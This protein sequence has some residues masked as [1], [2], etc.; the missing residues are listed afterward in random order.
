MI[1][2][3]LWYVVYYGW[4]LF[5]VFIAI[6]MRTGKDAGSVQDRGTQALLWIVIFASMTACEFIRRLLAPNMPAAASIAGIIVLIAGLAVRCIAIITL[7]KAFSANVAIKS[8]QSIQRTGIYSVL[9]H[10][11]YSG[12]LLIFLG[13]GLH[14]R[15]WQ[16]L[17][18]A[19]LPSTVALLYRI[20]IEEAVLNTT[21]GPDYAAYSRAT[22]RLIPGLY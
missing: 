14:S 2:P 20:R 8:A 6:R 21:F 17:A 19:F 11:S 18:V 4:I 10:P 9:R 12:L 13:I 7:G 22:K 3:L 5:E 15:N 1:L 16:G